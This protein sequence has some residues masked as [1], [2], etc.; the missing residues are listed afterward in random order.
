MADL[1]LTNTPVVPA[2]RKLVTLAT[3][4]AGKKN[5]GAAGVAP[6]SAGTGELSLMLRLEEVEGRQCLQQP[7]CQ[8]ARGSLR[9]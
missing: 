4:Q 8:A 2:F 7:L 3:F 9:L 6:L 1:K 5:E